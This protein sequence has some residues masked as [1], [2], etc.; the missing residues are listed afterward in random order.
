MISDFQHS[1][2]KPAASRLFHAFFERWGVALFLSAILTAGWWLPVGALPS[3]TGCLLKRFSGWDCPGC[4]LTRSF[5]ALPKGH[6]GEA[7]HFNWAGPI[8]YGVFFVAWLVQLLP[9]NNAGRIRLSALW[10]RVRAPLSLLIILLLIG[11]WL[12]KTLARVIPAG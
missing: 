2:K 10:A 7:F 6:I 11:H 3:W 12:I 1:E 8:L 4:G 9:V 5:M